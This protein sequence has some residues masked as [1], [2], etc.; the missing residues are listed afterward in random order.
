M[1]NE[2]LV[3]GAMQILGASFATFGHANNLQPP[4]LPAKS[5]GQGIL[6]LRPLTQVGYHMTG[7]VL[8]AANHVQAE[9]ENPVEHELQTDSRTLAGPQ[10]PGLAESGNSQMVS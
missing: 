2:P 5:L 8:G 3:D 10:G 1:D 9:H 4:T 7:D 6:P